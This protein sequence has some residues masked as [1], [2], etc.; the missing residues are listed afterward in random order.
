[1]PERVRLTRE[2]LRAALSEG[3]W[4]DPAS[5]LGKRFAAFA[6]LILPQQIHSER[7]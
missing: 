2:H 5:E 7:Q 3:R 6:E 4:M 1:M